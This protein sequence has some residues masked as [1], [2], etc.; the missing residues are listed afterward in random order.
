LVGEQLL[1]ESPMIGMKAPKIPKVIP[2]TFTQDD[3]HRMLAL[4]P[5]NTYLGI[6]NRAIILLF[7][8]TGIRLVEMAGIQLSDID[9]NYELIKIF[10]K[11]AKEPIERFERRFSLWQ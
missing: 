1:S 9:K 7:M 8:D 4:C 10:G 6:R 5:Q 3:I 11:G 2:R